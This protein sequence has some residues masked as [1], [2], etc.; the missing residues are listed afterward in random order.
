MNILE[1]RGYLIRYCSDSP[2]AGWISARQLDARTP[3]H[4]APWLALQT[5]AELSGLLPGGLALL[6]DLPHQ[7]LAGL[8]H[9]VRAAFWCAVG[10]LP[11]L[12]LHVRDEAFAEHLEGPLQGWF[13]APRHPSGPMGQAWRQGW[14]GWIPE[15]GVHWSLPGIGRAEGPPETPEEVP[16]GC[17]WGEVILPLG[18]LKEVGAGDVVPLL[19]DIQAGIERNLSLRMS[20]H[21]WPVAFPFQRRRTGWRLAVLGGREYQGASGAWEDVQGLLS[22]FAMSLSRLLKCPVHLG[23]CHDPAAASLLGHQAMREG[24]P[25]RYSLPIPP[26][27]PTFTP[28]L[29]ADPREASPL[30]SRAAV[31]AL[32]A[33]LL[34]HPPLALLRVPNLPQEAAVDVFLRGLEPVPAIRWIPPEVP[35]PGPFSQERP[36]AAASAF[37]PLADATQALQPRLFEELDALEGNPGVACREGAGPVD[38]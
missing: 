9:E 36:W 17:H 8:P 11:G 24:L 13:H 6:W 4:A 26:A 34:A 12:T 1:G 31:P 22:E 32:L 15:T 7:S 21:A 20:A 37:V 30:E 16:A 38:P 14:I 19:S 33:N 35:P 3:L 27:S 23:T 18:A 28:G 10:H 29:G 2:Y 25:W 5:L